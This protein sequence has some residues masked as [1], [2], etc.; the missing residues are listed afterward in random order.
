M[1]ITSGSGDRWIQYS[2]LSLRQTTVR[3]KSLIKCA[4]SKAPSWF[5]NDFNL[6]L[7]VSERLKKVQIVAKKTVKNL[8]LYPYD[9]V[10][11][12]KTETCFP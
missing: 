10:I 7:S 5:Q 2:S 12:P 8:A 6:S 3:E 1:K 11:G 4:T 9:A